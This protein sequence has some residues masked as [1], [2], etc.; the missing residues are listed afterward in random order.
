MD[1]MDYGSEKED[2]K[3]KTA[4][5]SLLQY[6]DE[7]EEELDLKEEYMSMLAEK[8]GIHDFCAFKKLMKCFMG[9]MGGM[10]KALDGMEKPEKADKPEPKGKDA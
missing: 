7:E 10:E 2:K 9:D 1:L 6:A 8:A 5:V 4:M 3:Q